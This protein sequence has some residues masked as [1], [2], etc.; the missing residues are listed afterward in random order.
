MYH[1]SHFLLVRVQA[2]LVLRDFAL[3]RLENLHHLSN[4]REKFRFDGIWHR[5]YA[6]IFGLTRFDI[7]GTRS[8]AALVVLAETRVTGTP[9]V[10][11]MD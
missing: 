4:L 1:A 10:T 11:C 6:I 8:V 7:H 5:R 3:T 9:S 2:G